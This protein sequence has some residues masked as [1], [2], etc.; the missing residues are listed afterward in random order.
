MSM[1]NLRK[2]NILKVTSCLR[3]VNI[4]IYR[5]SRISTKVNFKIIMKTVKINVVRNKC[6]IHFFAVRII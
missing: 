4:S 5:Q 3:N 6:S 2:Q 1:N